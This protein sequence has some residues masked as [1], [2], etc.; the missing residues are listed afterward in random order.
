M[1]KKSDKNYPL[2]ALVVA[3]H[4]NKE[5]TAEFLESLK[6]VTYPNYKIIII[7]DGSTD[8]TENMIK[9]KYSYVILLKGDGNLLWT[10]AVNMGIKKAIEINADYVLLGDNDCV[11]DPEFLSVL[12]DTAEKNHRAIVSPKTYYYDD[13]QRIFEA[14]CDVDWLRGFRVIGQGEIDRGQYDEQRDVKCACFGVLIPVS[15]FKDIGMLDENLPLYKSDWDF[16]YRAYKAGY[17][18]IY[19]P[20]SKCWHKVSSTAKKKIVIERS[21]ITSPIS[22]FIYSISSKSRGAP[23]SF[24]E[25]VYVYFKHFPLQLPYIVLYFIV[26]RILRELKSIFIRREE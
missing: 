6:N 20:R 13:P 25:F 21:F 5:D 4:N 14:G 15:V 24:R 2:V 1:N 23:L 12:V 18:I 17:R 9:D 26:R 19:E 7:D 8:G 11:V 10:R 16:T 3:V 22:T